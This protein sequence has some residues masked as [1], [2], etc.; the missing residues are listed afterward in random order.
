MTHKLQKL[1]SIDKDNPL[2]ESG[3]FKLE[4]TTGNNGIDAR[5]IADVLDRSHNVMRK[6]GLDINDTTGE[7]FYYALCSLSKKNIDGILKPDDFAIFC[8]DDQ[9][10]SLNLIDSI[11]NA[12]HQLPYNKRTYQ[13]GQRCLRK[14]IITRYACHA[15]T[16]EQTT[17]EIARSMGILPESDAW[18]NYAKY[19]LDNNQA[20]KNIGGGEK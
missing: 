18:Y 14:E 12:H 11:E 6:L 2:F 10:V 15:R 20:Q 5:L 4:K 3:I 17:H 8:F 1:L 19:K 9:I 16:N 7:E 13:H